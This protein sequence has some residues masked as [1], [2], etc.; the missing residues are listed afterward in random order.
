MAGQKA[1]HDDIAG[2]AALNEPARRSLYFH[3]VNR[4][5][6]VSR[7]DAA[8]A[9]GIS[10]TLAGWHLDKLAEEGLLEVTFRRLSGRQ[11]PGAG[12]PAK[13]Y[14]RSE[15][16]IEISLPQRHYELAAKVLAAAFE[17]GK[18]VKTAA[19]EFGRRLKVTGKPMKALESLGYAPVKDGGDIRLRNC[20][21]HGL[22]GEHKALVCGMN[23][24]LLE[25]ALPSCAARLDPQPGYCCVALKPA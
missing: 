14:R 25:G 13:L 20:P 3:V 18:D 8:K 2:L 16:S 24:G 1:Q 11:G 9:V 5:G 10:R 23:L 22:V 4:G 17:E 15:R 21:F 19:R 6:D 7:D 12:R